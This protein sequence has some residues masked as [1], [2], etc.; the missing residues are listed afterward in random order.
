M[1]LMSM[2][3]VKL[4]PSALTSS[5][6]L[7]LIPLTLSRMDGALTDGGETRYSDRLRLRR[8][9]ASPSCPR[10]FKAAV[11]SPQPRLRSLTY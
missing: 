4:R 10:T 7:I 2:L 3:L 9:E 8:G 5:F 1:L 6:H 11:F